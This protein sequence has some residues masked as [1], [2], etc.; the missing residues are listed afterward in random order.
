[1]MSLDPTTTKVSDW[2]YV[3]E[4]GAT[5]V[6]SYDTEKTPTSNPSFKRTV[7][8]LRKAPL[9]PNNGSTTR[10]AD[11]VQEDLDDPS[12][13]FQHRITSELV[14]PQHLP[15]LK[16]VPVNRAWLTELATYAARRRPETRRLKDDIDLNRTKAVLATDLVGGKGWAVEIKV[17]HR[18]WFI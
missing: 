8:R 18:P 12:V 5:M 2:K 14:P 11:E 15:Q 4:G 6:F 7:L 9:S 10:Q 16:S 3:S 13:E 17:C 1:M